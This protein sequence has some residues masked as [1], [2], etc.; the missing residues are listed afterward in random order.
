MIYQTNFS[1][2]IQ[3]LV[4]ML[5]RRYGNQAK[6]ISSVSDLG[7]MY[8]NYLK[9]VQGREASTIDQLVISTDYEKAAS[10]AIAFN[11]EADSMLDD[12]GQSS[13]IKMENYPNVDLQRIKVENA[14]QELG[15][16]S[17]D[18][19]SLLHLFITDIFILPSNGA[20]GGSS[21]DSIGLIWAN[22]K[23]SY[24]ITDVVEFLIHELTHHCMFIDEQR[25]GH[26]NY[27]NILDNTNW[28]DSAILK[29]P[30]PI[31]KVLHSIIVSL[32]IILFRDLVIGHPIKP[33][34]HPPTTMLID[35]IKKSIVS[36]K[37]IISINMDK[38]KIL[39][40]ARGMDLLSNAENT[41]AS[42]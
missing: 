21:S 39:V 23:E 2:Q 31:D 22:P 6:T 10:M 34:V 20:R 35:Q 38:N 37:N 25:Y 27:Q 28:A 42:Y 16:L 32:E 7:L 24:P 5:A 26:Y 8:R 29:K 12:M 40:S 3:N 14:I 30:R 41:I 11:G 36:I 15:L 1:D 13:I 17:S 33:K 9:E 18:H 4:F 19:Y